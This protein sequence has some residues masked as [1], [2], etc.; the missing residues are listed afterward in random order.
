M[1]RL[2]LATA[3]AIALLCASPAEG[4]QPFGIGI[5][6]PMRHRLAVTLIQAFDFTALSAGACTLPT[7]LSFS[8]AS[9]GYSVQT[10][11]S[12]LVASGGITSNDAPRCGRRL[13]ADAIGLVLEE[14]RTNT[15]LDSNNLAGWTLFNSTRGGSTTTAPDGGTTPGTADILFGSAANSDGVTRFPVANYL[16]TDSVTL[17]CWWKLAVGSTGPNLDDPSGSIGGFPMGASAA[18][19]RTA[20]TDSIASTSRGIYVRNTAQISGLRGWLAYAQVELGKFVTEVIPNSGAST[21]RAGERL[22]AASA[23]SYV[24]SGR[25]GFEVWLRP[26]AAPANYPAAIRLWTRGTDYAE[27]ST[28]GALTISIGGSTNTT[29]AAS[30]AWAAY[31]TVQIFISAGG[32]SASVVSYRVNGGSVV[33]PTVT[34]SALGSVSAG[35]ALDILCSNTSSQLSAW[36]TRLAFWKGA[37]KPAWAWLT[38]PAANDTSMPRAIAA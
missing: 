31:D 3:I 33:H 17:S 29:A 16:T 32:S 37:A 34:G 12:T 20:A 25:L 8:R 19:T 21:T 6:G 28:A 27:I 26:K 22:F 38:A 9:S 1:Q 35:G 7:G 36:M 18:W 5:P 15:A 11:T 30:F 4:I 14:A 10:G 23:A 13:D 2:R 24:A